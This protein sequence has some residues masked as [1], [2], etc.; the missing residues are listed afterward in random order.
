MLDFGHHDANSL[1][2]SVF[3]TTASN[4]MTCTSARRSSCLATSPLP[5]PLE[6]PPLMDSCEADMHYSSSIG[7]PVSDI[8]MM[9]DD[10]SIAGSPSPESPTIS[11][12]LKPLK[13]SW[14][15]AKHSTM[16]AFNGGRVS[17]PIYSSFPTGPQQL[18][19]SRPPPL[20]SHF[21]ASYYLSAQLNN[22]HAAPS[23][24][25]EADMDAE[26]DAEYVF[27]GSCLS[28]LSFGD[29]LKTPD[30]GLSSPL[31]RFPMVSTAVEAAPSPATPRTGRARSGAITSKSRFYMG[32]RDDCEQCRMN[33]PNHFAHFIPTA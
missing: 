7:S 16:D 6:C 20:V 15:N 10:V 22:D 9:A 29:E 23:P 30:H 5:P 26:M 31:A 8:D 2:N 25:R 18:R 21:P 32:F 28:N 3:A 13:P 14:L 11:H 4:A 24:I 1:P 17:T 12:F 27:A 19:A 33:V